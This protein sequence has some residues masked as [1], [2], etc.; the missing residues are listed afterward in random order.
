[1]TTPV[2]APGTLYQPGDLVRPRTTTGQGAVAPDDPSF[3]SGALASWTATPVGGA[4]SGALSTTYKFDG[5]YSFFWAGGSGSEQDGGIGCDLVNDYRAPV[6]AGQSITARAYF[7]SVP[8]HREHGVF[9]SIRLYWYNAS[10]EL[11][12]V[13]S[14][15]AYGD[16]GPGHGFGTTGAWVLSTITSSAPVG[17]VFCSVGAYLLSNQGDANGSYADTFS[18]D[19]VS[20]AVSD[21]FVFR[22]VQPAAG[23]SGSEEPIWPV[24]L[25]ET[26]YDNEVVWEAVA[27]S[28]VVWEASPILVSSGTEPDFPEA[29]DGSVVDGTIV[30]RAVSRRIT[31]E[32]C[33][34][35]KIVAIAAS[36]IFAGDDDIAAYC[37]TVNPLDWSTPNDA[38]YLPFGLQTYGAN[39]IAGMGLY[40]SNLVIFNSTG[41]QMWQVDQNPVNMAFLDGQPIPCSYQLSIQ[42]VANDLVFLTS[43][44]IR[45]ISIAG[46]STN[47]QAG[48]FGKQVDPLIKPLIAAAQ[49]A[50]F[51]PWGLFWPGQGQYWLFFGT[52]AMVLTMNGGEKDMSW[53]R[54]EYPY[55][56][57]D[58]CIDGTTLFLRS[59]DLVWEV[60]DDAN[61]PI[62]PA[63]DVYCDM[64]EAPVLSNARVDTSNHLSWTTV[65]GAVGY[66][67]YNADTN[68]L[69]I[70]TAATAYIDGDLGEYTD[71]SYYVVAYDV[72][73]AESPNS[74]TVVGNIGGPNA[75]TLSGEVQS[76]NESALLEWTEA[77]TD[78]G[79]ILGYKLYD[80]D[81]DT[82]IVDTEDPE[83][84]S[85]LDTGLDLDTVYS[86]YVVAYTAENDSAPSNIVVLDTG[87]P[88]IIVE[89]F[90]SSTTWTKRANLVSVEVFAVGAGGGGQA[91]NY[92]NANAATSTVAGGGGE[93]RYGAFLAAAL[94]STVTV[95]VGAGG[96][97]GAIAHGGAQGAFGVGGG[98]SSF[99]AHIVADGGHGGSTSTNGGRGGFQGSGGSVHVDGGSSGNPGG[100]S[101]LGAGGGGLGAGAG[102]TFTSARAGGNGSTAGTPTT[103]GAG[104]ASGGVNGTTGSNGASVAT[105]VD[106]GGAGGGGG[107]SAVNSGGAT[108]V[109]AGAGGAGGGYGGGGGGGGSVATAGGPPAITTGKGGDGAPGVVKVINYLS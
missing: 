93:Y 25:G 7:M 62:G 37:A 100:S 8:L 44:G 13:D 55:E 59:G 47:L 56:V 64:D 72:A 57:T 85:Y 67:L 106:L 1:M 16:G 88:G 58:W 74:N 52:T 92:N 28:R 71:H 102:A 3:E 35:S 54:Y 108:P 90:T 84:L 86:Y 4:A 78:G 80:A 11:L 107:G 63:D 79:P 77:T 31:D 91:G 34:H 12:A 69:I 38:G 109:V 27:T 36:K 6:V 60:S 97:G 83:I 45:N 98:D 99:G 101:T 66:L 23:F 15:P 18:W 96:T 95:T 68:A 103:G 43:L 33:P 65:V 75:P 9:G 39:P 22:A 51:E 49:L 14:V 87:H 21:S 20:P 42:P 81:T 61:T 26:V 41:Y 89:Y 32:K 94:A 10:D 17:A 2:W 82:L 46:G 24:V 70:D 50:G 5:T 19:Y 76:D 40:R 53:S 30:W 29:V 48:F 73:H 104:G 105:A